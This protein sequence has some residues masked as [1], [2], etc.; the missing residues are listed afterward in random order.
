MQQRDAFECLLTNKLCGQN[1][2][3]VMSTLVMERCKLR[4]HSKTF[5][6]NGEMLSS[7]YSPNATERCKY[8]KTTAAR[9][10]NSCAARL[11]ESAC[12]TLT[13]ELSHFSILV[14]LY[15]SLSFL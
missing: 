11:K 14:S 2:Q 13:F 7:V 8:S 12:D 6:H 1:E 4:D 3:R 5:V 15:T 10:K 9:A